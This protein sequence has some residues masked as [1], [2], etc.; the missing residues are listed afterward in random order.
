MDRHCP[1]CATAIRYQG[2]SELSLGAC[3]SC[4]TLMLFPAANGE[5]PSGLRHFTQPRPVMFNGRAPQRGYLWRALITLAIGVLLAAAIA[6][7]YTSGLI[8]LLGVETPLLQTPGL[9]P[10]FGVLSVI[11]TA[12]IVWMAI[13]HRQG[14]GRLCVCLIS[15]VAPGVTVGHGIRMLS[16]YRTAMRLHQQR[17]HA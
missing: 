5:E 11:F 1:S 10:R 7:L 16:R 2:G 8:R 9:I 3:P 6:A 12:G 14:F 17:Q 4:S 15:G 13:P